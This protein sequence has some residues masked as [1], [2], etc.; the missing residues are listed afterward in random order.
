MEDIDESD[1]FSLFEKL[2]QFN[3][4]YVKLEIFLYL[5]YRTLHTCRQVSSEWNDFIQNEIWKLRKTHMISLLN[6][7][8]KSQNFY[9]QSINCNLNSG[10]YIVADAQ[11]IGIGTKVSTAILLNIEKKTKTA[12]FVITLN[13]L[14]WDLMD[15]PE[16]DIHDEHINDVQ[17]DMTDKVIVAVAGSGLVKIWDRDT[18]TVLFSGAPHGHDAVLGVRIINNFIVT[19]GNEGGLAAY[20]VH[21][22]NNGVDLVYN[23]RSA[24]ASVAHLDSDGV[25]VLVG[26]HVN[27]VMWDFSERSAP[28]QVS[29]VDSGQVCCCVMSYPHA[30][31]TGLF[32]NHGLQVWNMVTRNK[33]R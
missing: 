26:T 18:K 13:D 19:G 8:W 4:M 3:L 6:K 28:V 31:C 1:R 20:T 29:S 32:I 33:I 23:N 10:F 11:N 5:D 16:N 2:E 17:V 30:F 14:I 15:E 7:N 24:V 9:K 22:D 27:M 25:R 12:E 21:S